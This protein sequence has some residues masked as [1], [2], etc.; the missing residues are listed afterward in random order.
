MLVIGELG[1]E[2]LGGGKGWVGVAGSGRGDG[3]RQRVVGSKW[4]L[5]HGHV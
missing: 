4:N 3:G 5:A 2:R 1:A